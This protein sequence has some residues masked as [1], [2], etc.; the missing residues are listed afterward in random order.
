[1]GLFIFGLSV[2]VI[3]GIVGGIMGFKSKKKNNT[4]KYGLMGFLHRNR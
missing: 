3:A 1:M 4:Y 2:S